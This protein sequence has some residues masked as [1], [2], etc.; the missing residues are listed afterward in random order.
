MDIELTFDRIDYTRIDLRQAKIFRRETHQ[1]HDI[2]IHVDGVG[3]L[4]IADN[5]NIVYEV[6]DWNRHVLERE[7]EAK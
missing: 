4:T 3:R 6:P 5:A 2:T 1:R 7:R